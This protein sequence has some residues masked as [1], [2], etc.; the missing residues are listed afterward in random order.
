VPQPVALREPAHLVSPRAVPY[1]RLT[2]FLRAVIAWAA[3][4]VA[5][6]LVNDRPWWV[7]GLAIALVLV[8]TAHVLVMPTLRYRIHRW[9]VTPEAIHTRS[10]WLS[11]EQ[12]VAPLSRVQTVDSEQHALMRLFGLA[13]VTVTTASAAGPIGIQCLDQDVASQLVAE[14]T[15]Y[16]AR[17]AGDAT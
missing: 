12:R 11:L 14:L 4:G 15:E 10:G 13:T 5:V 3:A 1:W 7:T 6:V 2:A 9:E 8:S 17:T 16:A